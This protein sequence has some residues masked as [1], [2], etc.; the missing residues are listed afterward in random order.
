M[1]SVLVLHKVLVCAVV[2]EE[3]H[4]AA[5][6]ENDLILGSVQLLRSKQKYL[7]P[8]RTFKCH[9]VYLS[10]KGHT[11][12]HVNHKMLVHEG[13]EKTILGWSESCEADDWL[14]LRLY[15]QEAESRSL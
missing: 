8:T 10:Q 11:T 13:K 1:L 5:S 7:N 9:I 4:S 12:V 2:E 3:M 15:Q 14:F 6:S